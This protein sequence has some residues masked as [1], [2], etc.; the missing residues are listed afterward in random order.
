MADLQNRKGIFSTQRRF[1]VATPK[2]SVVSIKGGNSPSRVSQVY[3]IHIDSYPIRGGASRLCLRMRRASVPF[4]LRQTMD[5][6][7]VMLWGTFFRRLSWRG[8]VGWG[9]VGWGVGVGGVAVW[10]GWRGVGWGGVRS[11]GVGWGVGGVG[12]CPDFPKAKVDKLRSDRS[13]FGGVKHGN[14]GHPD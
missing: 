4:R 8:V 1:S 2:I 7:D 3:I 10:V 6:M 9:G 5:S 12:G 13:T 11:G 14:G